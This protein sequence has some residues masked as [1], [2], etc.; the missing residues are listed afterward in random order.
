MTASRSRLPIWLLIAIGLGMTIGV[1]V[2]VFPL[3]RH[4]LVFVIV[5]SGLAW[6][7]RTASDWVA[8]HAGPQRG[9]VIL[10]LVLFGAWFALAAAGPRQLQN[11]GFGPLRVP[12]EPPDP[13]EL[14]PAGSRGPLSS[15]GSPSPD[16]EP[17][18]PL[19]DLLR[20]DPSPE[21]ETPEAPADGRRGTPRV[22]LHLSSGVSRAGEGVVLI[23]QLRGDGRPVR[24][25]IEFLVG[26][27]VVDCRL[28][29]V[30]GDTSQAEFRLVGMKPGT[31]SLRARYSGSRSFENAESATV[32]HRVADK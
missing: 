8:E 23:A 19:G 29:R 18:S 1:T 10:G 24:G 3:G 2:A 28:A 12:S 5:L 16:E 22:T 30:Q 26:D 6:L 27:E 7:L 17:R 31:Y 9:M 13:F 15:L 20:R 25:Y 21:P 14:R 32:Q 4:L 11:F